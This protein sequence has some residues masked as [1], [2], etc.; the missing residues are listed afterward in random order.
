MYFRWSLSISDN[1][2]FS[3]VIYTNFTMFVVF[4]TSFEYITLDLH[5][6]GDYFM[7]FGTN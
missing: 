6:K 3:I 1:Y 5:K 4:F 2:N 7:A